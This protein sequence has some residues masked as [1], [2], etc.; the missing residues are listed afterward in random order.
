MR[1][2]VQELSQEDSICSD[3]ILGAAAKSVEF[4]YFHS[5]PDRHNVMQPS[6]RLLDL[7]ERFN[8]ISSA[9]PVEG[10]RFP[11]DAPFLRGCVSIR[12][13]AA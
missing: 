6:A 10:A 13:K 5:E 3:T 9:H 7:D 11:Y 2:F 4:G 12:K 8:Q 1:V